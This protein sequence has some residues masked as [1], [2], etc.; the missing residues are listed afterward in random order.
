MILFSFTILVVP[1]WYWLPTQF[2]WK[3]NGLEERD[4]SNI[5]ECVLNVEIEWSEEL[6]FNQHTEPIE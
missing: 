1:N 5:I 2:K 6:K 4:H 3:L